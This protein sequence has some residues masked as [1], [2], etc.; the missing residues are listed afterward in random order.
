MKSIAIS[1]LFLVTFAY[2]GTEKVIY[3]FQGGT[4]GFRPYSS[5]IFDQ[6]GNL[7][8][9]TYYGGGDA[10]SFGCGT[11]F[12]LSPDGQGG[13]TE[14]VLYRFTGGQD[15][16]QPFAGLILDPQGNLYVTTLGPGYGYGCPPSCGSVFELSPGSAGWTITVLHD[17][18]GGADGDQPITQLAMDAAGNLYGTTGFGG[19]NGS[20]V[21]YR[22]SKTKSSTWNFA[23][24]PFTA[25]Q[26]Q[27]SPIVNKD[28]TIYGAALGGPYNCG[29][30]YS[31]SLNAQKKVVK[32]VLYAFK[33]GRDGGIPLGLAQAQDGSFYGVSPQNY[34]QPCVIPPGG[35]AF[36]LTQNQSGGW[37]NQIIYKFNTTPAIAPVSGVLIAPSGNLFGFTDDYAG[38]V[39]ELTPQ[40]D[41]TF[42]ESTLYGF[43]GGSDGWDP[44]GVPVMDASGNLYGVTFQGGNNCAFDIQCGT[45]FEVTP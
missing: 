13:W 21:I 1:L 19:A 30:L 42:S 16:E 40:S 27:G 12:E 18:L 36:H 38:G 11:V 35:S 33:G 32:K 41:G 2:A 29:V 39:Y 4:D 25:G 37:T 7:Y 34:Q 20:G 10:C 15:G 31:F 3:T 6:A 22:L 9:T 17:F 14:S 24:L 43:T 26:P 44:W 23:A 5:L 45:V 28:G 8:G